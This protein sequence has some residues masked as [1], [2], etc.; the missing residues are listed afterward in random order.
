MNDRSHQLLRVLVLLTFLTP[1]ATASD[2][3][4]STVESI[5]NSAE[6]GVKTGGSILAIL[7][8]AG[9]LLVCFAGYRFF[10]PTLFACGF[11]GGGV[12][13]ATVIEH[14]FKDKSWMTTASWIGFA[15]GGLIIGSI[16]VSLYA[17]GIFAAGAAGGVFL[18]IAL[19]TSFG[20]KIYPSNPDV[21]LII[22]IVALGI[23]AGVLALK[24]EKPALIV[25][26][27]LFG[28][29]VLV[30]GVGYFAGDY[31]NAD[32]LKRYRSQDSNGDWIYDIPS[33]WWAYLAGMAVLFILGM[34]AQFNKT[35]REGQ[36]HKSHSV[37]A[38]QYVETTTPQNNQAQN[39]RYGDPVAHV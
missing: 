27:S 19:N 11:V 6:D 35:S 30:W 17:F 37:P 10:R 33:A 8:I 7:A 29:G 4:S 15:L 16:V 5:F 39:I 21:V 20:Y 12:L 24:L 38:T 32:D 23:T 26:T 1:F 14:A 9:G 28:A 34:L 13:I 3:A 36:Y 25:T 22:L 31:P 18:A 2:T